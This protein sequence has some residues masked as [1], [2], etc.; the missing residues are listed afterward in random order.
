MGPRVPL[1][2][3]AS[4]SWPSVTHALCPE[5]QGLSCRR[6]PGCVQLLQEPTA[7]AA[8]RADGRG[9]QDSQGPEGHLLAH[10]HP[11]QLTEPVPR[12]LA[13]SRVALP[14]PEGPSNSRGWLMMPASKG[15]A[16]KAPQ[17]A[18]RAAGDDSFLTT[19][20]DRLGFWR[21]GQLTQLGTSLMGPGG[22]LALKCPLSRLG[23]QGH[24][25][26]IGQLGKQGQAGHTEEQAGRRGGWTELSDPHRALSLRRGARSPQ[27]EGTGRRVSGEGHPV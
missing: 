26:H 3:V 23:D 19:A 14:G 6:T 10:G 9:G 11:T 25:P 20:E 13:A 4:R 16:E 17:P 7:G 2:V 5:A 22:S 8:S 27:E 21:L 24:C 18:D 12:A 1:K 15:S